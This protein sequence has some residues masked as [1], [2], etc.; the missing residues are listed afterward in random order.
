VDISGITL[1]A[2]WWRLL[3]KKAWLPARKEQRS[4]LKVFVTGADGMLGSNIVREL[5]R[6]G[7]GVR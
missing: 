6:Q 1:T 3:L 2:F 7:H 4:T 5:I